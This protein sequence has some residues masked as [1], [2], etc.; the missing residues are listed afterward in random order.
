MTQ[1]LNSWTCRWVKTY[2]Y[3][4]TSTLICRADLF[5]IAPHGNNQDVL[6]QVAGKINCG[7]FIHSHYSQKKE[8]QHN[9][10]WVITAA[11]VNSQGSILS[12]KYPPKLHKINSIYIMFSNWE[13]YRLREQISIIE[14]MKGDER[15]LWLWH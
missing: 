1:Q 5:R 13:Y 2:V 15:G 3:T 6:Q 9:I 12:R 7:I 10:A 11:Y 4:V 8:K 14:V